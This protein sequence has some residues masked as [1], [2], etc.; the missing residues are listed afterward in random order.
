MLAAEFLV[1]YSYSGVL[2]AQFHRNPERFWY[3]DVPYNVVIKLVFLAVIF[4]KGRRANITVLT[5]AIL[6]FLI[7]YWSHRAIG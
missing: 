6:L 4:A 5:A 1:N 2:I 7:P 3:W